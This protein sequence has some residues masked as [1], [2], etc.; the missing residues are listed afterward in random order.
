MDHA[1]QEA[2]WNKAEDFKTSQNDLAHV[3][4]S[5]FF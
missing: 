5:F 2:R 4:I 1:K 3:I